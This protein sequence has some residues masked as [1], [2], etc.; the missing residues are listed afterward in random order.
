MSD[1]TFPVKTPFSVIDDICAKVADGHSGPGAAYAMIVGAGFSHGSVPLTR[2]LLNERIGDYYYLKDIE[3]PGR[4]PRKSRRLSADFWKEFN[5]AALDAGEAAVEVDR[6]GLP[7]QTSAA[8]QSLFTYRVANVL[9]SSGPNLTQGT[10]L[11]RLLAQRTP[12]GSPPASPRVLAGEKFVRDFLLN[13]LDPGGYRSSPSARGGRSDY[14]TTGRQVVNSAHFFLASVLELQQSGQLWKLRPFCRTIFTTNFDTLLQQA[15]HLVNVLYSLTDRPEGG[16]QPSDFPED[17]PVVHLVYTHGSIL[18]HN[19]G[20][21]VDEL[22]TLRE[23]NCRNLAEYLRTRDVLVIGYGGW[24]DSLMAALKQC[25]NTPQC[26]YWCNVF[27][28][29]DAEEK[30]GAAV[31]HLL[32]QSDDR[33]WYVPLGA[34]GAGGFMA[35]LYHALDPEGGIPRLLRDP[36][37]TFLDRLRLIDLNDLV[38]AAPVAPL[39]PGTVFPPPVLKVSG[40]R[41]RA[42]AT[43][44]L[45]GALAFL[46]EDAAQQRAAEKLAQVRTLLELGS[47]AALAGREDEAAQKWSQAL[48]LPEAPAW[49]AAVAANDLGKLHMRR[50]QI[51]FAISAY[52]RS[53]EFEAHSPGLRVEALTNR[54]AARYESGQIDQ[55]VEDFSAAI[56]IWEDHPPAVANATAACA[57]IY[58]AIAYL[59]NGDSRRADEDVRRA[60]ALK[61]VPAESFALIEGTRGG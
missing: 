17:D 19:A 8:Y 34:E 59:R 44:V 5:A 6:N 40:E 48:A 38:L 25:R 9:F 56:G 10:Y 42:S 30:L 53:I 36:I 18:R 26:L 39:R 49:E 20:S 11:A 57:L 23:K 13:V 61:G 55:A 43:F 31:C 2:E 24:D 58:R 14:V 27:P 3:G 41:M 35:R 15:L 7:V 12:R 21:T 33:A 47:A 52:T 22:G 50:G 16:L 32:Q 51:D 46:I 4:D 37:G 1:T 54:G 28:E 60:R 29:E 45:R